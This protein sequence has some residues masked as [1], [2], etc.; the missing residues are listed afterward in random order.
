MKLTFI[1]DTLSSGGSERV[2][3]VIAN[4]LS[5]DYDIEIIC[6]RM[7]VTYYPLQPNVK[8][9]FAE[10]ICGNS[11]LKKFIWLRKYVSKDSIVIAFMVP[12]YVFTLASL[13]FT[14]HKVIVSERNDPDAASTFRRIARRLLLWRAQKIVVQT[15]SI[16]DRMPRYGSSKQ[17]IIYNPI[18]EKYVCGKGLETK[19]ENL[20]ISVGRLSPQKNQKM[21][22]DGFSDFLT[23]YPNFRLEI[24]G[25][26]EIHEE[27]VS[28]I[29]KKN[30]EEKVLLMGRCNNLQDVLPKAKIFVMTSDYE[31][32]SNAMVEA[33]YI[34][35]PVVTTAVSGTEEL[36]VNGENGMVIPIGDKDAFTK[37]I[38]NLAG[39]EKCLENMASNAVKIRD[40]VQLSS[41]IPQWKSLINSMLSEKTNVR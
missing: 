3:S 28:Y 37:A 4:E 23:Q 33:L 14:E 17:I 1:T 6:L 35:L 22:I 30:L 13:L 34:G 39:D 11:L 18:S 15:K 27:L 29:K 31:G 5:G 2:M 16:A 38:I 40:K 9:T 21:M 12:V 41:I 32:M 20:L 26:G 8:V 36:I 7:H 24:Y 25:E 19:K 10:D